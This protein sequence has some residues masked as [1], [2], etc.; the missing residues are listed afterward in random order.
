MINVGGAYFSVLTNQ[1]APFLEAE[2][3]LLECV[4]KKLTSPKEWS[5][6]RWTWE[7]YFAAHCCWL[8]LYSRWPKRREVSAWTLLSF[9]S[10]T[11]LK[12]YPRAFLFFSQ[13]YLGL[14]KY[15]ARL[16][17]PRWHVC[18]LFFCA[19]TTVTSTSVCE[20]VRFSDWD[21]EWLAH[22]TRAQREVWISRPSIYL[23]YHTSKLL[24]I[25]NNI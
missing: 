12:F 4:R 17:K 15:G 25:Y 21:M 7:R 20:S 19:V 5:I 16:R 13:Y 10:S 22:A 1:S 2:T 3:R 8:Y 24:L 11:F 6:P 14:F 18:L 9:P 23:H